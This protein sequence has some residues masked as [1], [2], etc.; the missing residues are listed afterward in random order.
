MYV[1]FAFWNGILSTKLIY[2]YITFLFYNVFVTISKLF[3]GMIAFLS[4][5]LRAASHQW[6]KY[7]SLMWRKSEKALNRYNQMKIN[8][9]HNSW[10]LE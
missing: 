10:A 2:K 8:Y 7:L 5:N 4:T 3:D 1:I 9:I 6:K